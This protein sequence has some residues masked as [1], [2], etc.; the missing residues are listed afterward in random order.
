MVTHKKQ[1]TKK[2]RR[3]FTLV[4]LL[5]VIVVLGI[6]TTIS[7]VSYNGIQQRAYNTH[8]VTTIQ[9]F[10][11]AIETYQTYHARRYPDTEA[12]PSNGTLYKTACIGTGYTDGNCGYYR[13]SGAG[14]PVGV[15]G[16]ENNESPYL[17]SLL[18]SDIGADLGASETPPLG[19][20]VSVGEDCTAALMTTGPT[21]SLYCRT[22]ASGVQWGGGNPYGS[23]NCPNDTAYQITYPLR[24]LNQDCQIPN[25]RGSSTTLGYTTC[26]IA[27][28]LPRPAS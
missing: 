8:M 11:D 28:G 10:I 27:G 7:V 1:K 5:V 14:C 17:Q 21:Y 16:Y 12:T 15:V 6:L 9:Q 24:G 20:S 3:G 18:S 13:F 23:G 19:T 25:A 4:E 26:S 2:V 22:S